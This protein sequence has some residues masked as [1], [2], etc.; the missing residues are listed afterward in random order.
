MWMNGKSGLETVDIEKN[1]K[2][3][4]F[5]N[6]KSSHDIQNDFIDFGDSVYTGFLDA[7]RLDRAT[8][9]VSNE[10]RVKIETS[11]YTCNL[12]KLNQITESAKGEDT[13]THLEQSSTS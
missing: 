1:Y 2:K 5:I 7:I 6:E 12:V 4:T 9:F 11:I 8:S 3:A 10:S 13:T